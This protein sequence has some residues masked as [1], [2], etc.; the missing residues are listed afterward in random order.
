MSSKDYDKIAALEKAIADKYECESL[1]V[2]K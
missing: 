2:S 1:S